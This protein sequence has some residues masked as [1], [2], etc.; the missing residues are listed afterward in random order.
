MPLP[1]SGQL[2]GR[3][4]I[5]GV[6]AIVAALALIAPTA[7]SATKQKRH[8]AKAALA[9]AAAGTGRF[10]E[11][12]CNNDSPIQQAIRLTMACTDIRGFN[13]VDN[14]NTWTGRFYDN[15]HY[16]GHD[17]PDM[18]FYSNQ[19]GSGND[20]TWTETLPQD[21]AALPTVNT[22]GSDVTHWFE[23]TPTPVVLDGDVR[24]EVLSPEEVHARERFQRADVRG[25]S[26]HGLLP[27][28]R[29][30]VHGDAVLSAR[31]RRRR[32]V[33]GLHQLR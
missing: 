11:L 15:G 26:D 28:R 27:R 23:L 2:R 25:R 19:P 9:R 13:N 5:I 17:E 12:D 30:R 24:S 32:R 4:G 29:C 10:G 16:I 6:L 1:L 21:P 22:P 31:I 33:C 7:A 18:T 3:R 8:T 14:A 20:V